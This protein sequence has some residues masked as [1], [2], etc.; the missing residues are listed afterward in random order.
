MTLD[1]SVN[2][3]EYAIINGKSNEIIIPH[4]QSMKIIDIFSIFELKY[5]KTRVLSGLRCKEKIHEDLISPSEATYS[6]YNKGYYHLTNKVV[7]G[8]NINNINNINIKTIQIDDID[9]NIDG[10]IDDNIY[11]KAVNSSMNLIGKEQLKLYLETNG[12]L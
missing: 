3:I 5:G 2:L 4:I 9:G 7:C 6:Y 8:I 12:Y 11:I 10:N 1:H